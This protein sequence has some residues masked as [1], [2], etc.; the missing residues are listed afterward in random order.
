MN[1][2]EHVSSDHHQMS[3]L[4][5]PGLMSGGYTLPDLCGGEGTPPC[6]LSQGA[7]DVTYPPPQTE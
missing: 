1:K 3:L 7:F 5:Y 4:G 2:F 6:D